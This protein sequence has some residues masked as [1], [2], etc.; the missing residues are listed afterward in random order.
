MEV[1]TV[2]WLWALHYCTALHCTALHRTAPH[3]TCHAQP[4]TGSTMSLRRLM[5]M[6]MLSHTRTQG[7]YMYAPQQN[8]QR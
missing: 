5:L 1:H 4:A 7:G 2:F 3:C 8:S 6:L